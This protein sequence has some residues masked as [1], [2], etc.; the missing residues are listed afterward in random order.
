MTALITLTTAGLDTGPFDLYTELDGFTVPFES[1][2]LKSSLL[3]GYTS[4]I[5]PDNATTVRVQS[6]GV[7]VNY[8]DIILQYPTTTTTTTLAPI[9]TTTTTTVI[10]PLTGVCIEGLSNLTGGKVFNNFDFR[11]KDGK[12]IQWIGATITIINLVADG[13]NYN[14]ILPRVWTSENLTFD[15]DPFVAGWADG[16]ISVGYEFYEIGRAHV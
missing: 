13:I 4:T 8:V 10:A 9:T 14:P 5:V 6:I 16:G 11:I 7:C 12:T 1:N 3:S 15:H 2:I